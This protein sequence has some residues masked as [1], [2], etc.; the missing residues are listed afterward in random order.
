MSSPIHSLQAH[1]TFAS[2]SRLRFSLEQVR[3]L[4]AQLPQDDMDRALDDLFLVLEACLQVRE[5]GT[6]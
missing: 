1:P 5:E 4:A 3:V 6:G 2:A